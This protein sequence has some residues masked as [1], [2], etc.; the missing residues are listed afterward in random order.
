MNETELREL[1]ESQT[2]RVKALRPYKAQVLG[3]DLC[4]WC[5]EPSYWV[6][7]GDPE[8]KSCTS[9]MHN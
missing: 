1:F 8:C 6:I 3:V 5:D 7:K 9:I 4:R 2:A